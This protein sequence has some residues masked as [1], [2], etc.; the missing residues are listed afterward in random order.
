MESVPKVNVKELPSDISFAYEYFYLNSHAGLDPLDYTPTTRAKW[1]E[2]L[3]ELDNVG[4]D[5]KMMKCYERVYYKTPFKWVP[6]AFI[7]K[8]D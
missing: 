7:N 5:I 6:K 4:Q 2:L 8:T 3:Q 1:D